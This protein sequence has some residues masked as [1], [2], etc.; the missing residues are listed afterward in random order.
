MSPIQKFDVVVVG[1]GF[2]GMYALHYLRKLGFAVRVLEIAKDVGGTWY[3]NRYPGARCDVASLEYSYQFSEELQQQWHWSEKYAAQAEILEYANHVA[4]R[5]DLRRDIQFNTHVSAMH[6]SAANPSAS[7]QGG[8]GVGWR[9]TTDNGEIFQA[10][11]CIMAT[12]CLSSNNIPDFPGLDD[13]QGLL[14]HTGQWP[15]QEVDFAAKRVGM[16]GTGSS[17]IQIAPLIAAEADS[18][19]IFQRTASYSIPAHNASMDAD[20]ERTIKA[21]YAR[22]REQNSQR[23]AALNNNPNSVPALEVSAAERESN[24]QQ[25]WE[26]GGLPFLASFS[27]LATSLEAN[28]TAAEFVRNKIRGI[29][30]DPIVAE[31]LCPQT[32]MG[33]KRLC[34]DSDYY[35][36]F[37]R[38]NVSLIDV[39]ACPIERIT[40]AGIKTANQEYV[41]DVLIMATGFD[42]MTGALLRIDIRG[43]DGL[44]LRKKWRDGPKNYLGLTANGFPNFF[45]ITGP[46]SPSVLANMI[47]AIEQHVEWI[48]D[49]LQHL[50]ANS[51]S[52]IEASSKAED[53]W[54]RLV[55]KI[56]NKTLFPSGCNSWYTGANIPGK[57]RIFMPYL[58]YPSYVEKCEQ[59]AS[60]G[61]RGF[62][63]GSL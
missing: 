17:A 30:K 47:V 55:N 22:F 21:D 37:N 12:G 43:R 40:S 57:P 60:T 61:Y 15:H 52:T 39:N 8:G 36:T 53:H 35:Q 26:A 28:K 29:V 14:L 38:D 7:N 6:F 25:R 27:D 50:R 42:A 58:G 23:Y 20:H 16:I 32:V 59:V 33:C 34:V 49:C 3:W 46:G 19:M 5:F 48:G 9:I 51:V 41:F 11:F 31:L 63:L 13:Y 4:D 1:A 54:V 45:T 24:Y 18:L 44:S 2:A 10:Q 56:A 62:E